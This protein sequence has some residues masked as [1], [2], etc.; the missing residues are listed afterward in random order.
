[1]TVR[2]I[3]TLLFSLPILGV[4]AEPSN[5]LIEVTATKSTSAQTKSLQQP[6]HIVADYP[7]ILRWPSQHLDLKT[8]LNT[9]FVV[10]LSPNLS[11]EI[12]L[13]NG[14]SQAGILTFQGHAFNDKLLN[15][16]LTIGQKDFYLNLNHYQDNVQ[17]R[18]SGNV[19]NGTGHVITVNQQALAQKQR[20]SEPVNLP[21]APLGGTP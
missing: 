13:V 19:Q 10:Q 2:F 17:Y 4:A 12:T 6:S 5:L 1:M 14:K 3:C 18:I 15:S 20:H 21:A 8:W 9:P 7:V 11:T 16:S